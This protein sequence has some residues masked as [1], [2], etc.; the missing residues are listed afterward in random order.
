MA[1]IRCEDINTH[2]DFRPLSSIDGVRVDLRYAGTNNF[3]GRVLYRDLDCAW[4]RREAAEGLEK[5]RHV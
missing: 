2:A 1:M 4:L 5:F 3:A